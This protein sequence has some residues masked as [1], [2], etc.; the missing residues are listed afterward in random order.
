M[1]SINIFASQTLWNR[2]M[3]RRMGYLTLEVAGGS[4]CIEVVEGVWR[5]GW[6]RKKARCNGF[7]GSCSQAI[8]KTH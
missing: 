5:M 4:V 2:G 7:V 3:P 1:C 8:D 6:D